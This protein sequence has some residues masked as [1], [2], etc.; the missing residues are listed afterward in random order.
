MIDIGVKEGVFQ[1]REGR[2][3]MRPKH[4]E[5]PQPVEINITRIFAPVL[6]ISARFRWKSYVGCTE[7]LG[8]LEEGMRTA[9]KRE[10]IRRLLGRGA[11]SDNLAL[12]FPEDAT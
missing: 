6:E 5:D 10:I 8:L 4:V 12:T 2:P 1:L 11:T 3:G 7:L 9:S